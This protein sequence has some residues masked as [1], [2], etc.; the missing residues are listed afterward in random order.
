MAFSFNTILTGN[1][2]PHILYV[3]FFLNVLMISNLTMEEC[4]VS[5]VHQKSYECHSDTSQTRR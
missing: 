1:P 4:P 5:D 2:L 3:I